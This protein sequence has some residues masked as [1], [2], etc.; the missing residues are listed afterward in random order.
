MSP[1][2][3]PLILTTLVTTAT[4]TLADTG[5]TQATLTL[6]PDGACAQT[7]NLATLTVEPD[8]GCID[9]PTS[10]GAH[11]VPADPNDKTFCLVKFFGEQ[12]CAGS[13]ST[14]HEPVVADIAVGGTATDCRA[15]ANAGSFNDEQVLILSGGAQSLLMMC[16]GEATS[17]QVTG[18]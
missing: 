3:L 8:F 15:I 12:Q 4:F 17:L 13:Q 5:A 18:S 14:N 7:P 2:N 9:I 1:S 6:F 10:F 11:I 16:S